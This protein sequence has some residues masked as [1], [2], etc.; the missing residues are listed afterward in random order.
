MTDDFLVGQILRL[1]HLDF[2][3][4][5]PSRAK[6]YIVEMCRTLSRA[7]HE[8]IAVAVIDECIESGAARPTPHDI[9]EAVVRR[10]A[11]AREARDRSR[12]LCAACDGLGTIFS[13]REYRGEIYPCAARCEACAGTGRVARRNGAAT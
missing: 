10:N 2:F 9:H 4:S 12:P 13:E 8:G 6:S 3:P 5:E 1:A 7:D 11:A